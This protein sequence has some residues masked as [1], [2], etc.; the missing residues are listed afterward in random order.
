MYYAEIRSEKELGAAFAADSRR[1]A[2]QV[3][4]L[5]R[6]GRYREA[7]KAGSELDAR[8]DA[9]SRHVLLRKYDSLIQPRT[10]GL[11]AGDKD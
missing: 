5:L 8:A 10:G 11:P 1:I 4:K 7:K 9:F 3:N 6:Q 2:A